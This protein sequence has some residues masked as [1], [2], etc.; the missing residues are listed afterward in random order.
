MADELKIRDIHR[1]KPETVLVMQGG[2]SLGAYEC[3]V[4]KALAKH[5]IKFDIIAGTS[6]GAVNAGIIIGART[7]E[8]AKVLEDFWLTI[9][10]I[11][12]PSYLPDLTRAATAAM[13]AAMYGNSHVFMPRWLN[14]GGMLGSNLPIWLSATPNVYD[15]EPLKKTLHRF[16]DFQKLNSK[17]TPRLI[18]TST[19]IKESEPVS[20]DSAKTTIDVDHLVASA[21][22]PFYGISWTEKDGKF[23]WDGALLSNTPLREVIEASP[24][25][26]K[27][28]Y[29]VNLFP[30]QQD[31]LP[32]NMADSW[33]RAKDIMHTD[34]TD[35]NI[36]LSKVISRYLT[37]L[38]EMHDILNNVKLEQ[39][40][41]ERFFKVER[42][43]HKLAEQRGSVIQEI[44]RIERKEDLHFIF[45]DADFSLATIKK[46]IN[47]GEEDAENAL[48][49]K[50]AGSDSIKVLNP[51]IM[52]GTP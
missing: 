25:L 46:L 51:N 19:D 45:E 4:Y 48:A 38:R 2:G 33:H 35:H 21:G 6:I 42:E 20:F 8:P 37:L 17:D 15:I 26:D 39:K 18:V 3:G 43:Y 23:L 41:R 34:R 28:V 12:I 50:E 7:D 24:K 22:Y 27:K 32:Q 1:P 10:D 47:Q 52:K 44:I 14:S 11:S 36:R 30:R 9:A 31:E 13:S 16:V 49:K 40:D 5:D 29:I